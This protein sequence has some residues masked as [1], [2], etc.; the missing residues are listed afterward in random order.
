MSHMNESCHL[1]MSH[2]THEWVMSYMNESCDIW[3]SHVTRMNESCHIHEAVI[4]HMSCHVHS[5]KRTHSYEWSHNP[6]QKLPGGGFSTPVPLFC[7]ICT[8]N[9]NKTGPFETVRRND[10]SSTERIKET[11]INAIVLSYHRILY[12]AT[13]LSILSWLNLK[14]N[15]DYFSYEYVTW[16]IHM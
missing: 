9:P 7:L 4:S 14:A 3:M 15:K 10:V 1:W 13:W 11:S 6:P 16:R 2:V 12:V 8:I 5:Q